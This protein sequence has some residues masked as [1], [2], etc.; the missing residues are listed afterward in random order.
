MTLLDIIRNVI[1]FDIALFT[2]KNENELRDFLKDLINLFKKIHVRD[3]E[4]ILQE[5]QKQNA[6]YTLVGPALKLVILQRFASLEPN[7]IEIEALI[8]NSIS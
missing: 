3:C 4:Q 7:N 8:K 2:Y 1:Q 6:T 5:L